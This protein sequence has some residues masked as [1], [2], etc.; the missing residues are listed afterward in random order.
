MDTGQD[1]AYIAG[2]LTAHDWRAFA[3]QL[4][5]DRGEERWRRAFDDYFM[6]RIDRRYLNPIAILQNE[7]T[8]VGEGFAIMAIQCSL[9]EFLESTVQGVRYRYPKRGE[10]LGAYEYSGSRDIFVNFLTERP[11][12]SAEFDRG[13]ALE[14]YASIRCGMLH[15][16]QTKNGWR[17]W[18]QS[19]DGR[20]V[21]ADMRVVFRND[22]Q[23][24]LLAYVSWYKETLVRDSQFQDAFVRKFD[25]LST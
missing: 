5:I 19:E 6:Q 14:F 8:F 17:I 11:P 9:I 7:G 15:E 10:V 22:F 24:A 1:Q 2:W 25:S 4:A 20:M 18:A 16:A 12:F 21:D 13:L 3:D 23:R